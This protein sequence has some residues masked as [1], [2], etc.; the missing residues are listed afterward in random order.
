VKHLS[1]APWTLSLL[2]N[3]GLGWKSLQGTNALV[4][5]EKLVNYGRIK[6]YR[7]NPT[8]SLNLNRMA[9]IFFFVFFVFPVGGRQ[10]G[11]DRAEVCQ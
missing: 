8:G 3:I 11:D 10:S 6:F 9:L 4:Y 5:Y 1:G 7:I 2:T